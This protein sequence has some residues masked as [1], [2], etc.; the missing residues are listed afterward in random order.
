[1]KVEG[2]GETSNWISKEIK[3]FNAKL[4]DDL[5]KVGNNIRNRDGNTDWIITD[6]LREGKFKAVPK[7]YKEIISDKSQKMSSAS[8]YKTV[9]DMPENVYQKW[10]KNQLEA[11]I[12]T[13]DISG[14]VDTSNPIYRFYEKEVQKYLKRIRP[15]MKRITDPQGVSWYELTIKPEEAKLPIEAFGAVPFLMGKEEEPVPMFK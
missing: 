2:L 11:R 8:K 10:L 3:T 15:E 9:G 5:L 6:I 4:T 13:F 12:E 7:G 1:M 14:K